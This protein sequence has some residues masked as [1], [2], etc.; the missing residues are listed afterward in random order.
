MMTAPAARNETPP[1]TTLA[2]AAPVYGTMVE[3]GAALALDQVAETVE[4]HGA[5]AL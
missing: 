1:P 3:V 4:L 5:G 2:E